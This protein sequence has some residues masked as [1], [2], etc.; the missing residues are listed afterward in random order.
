[1]TDSRS[2]KPAEASTKRDI[3]N[4]A[5]S[6]PADSGAD[7]GNVARGFIATRTDPII[8]RSES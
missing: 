1:M 5:N 2:P 8:P 4:F 6:L 3:E 7:A